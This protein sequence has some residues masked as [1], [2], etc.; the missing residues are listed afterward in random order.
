MSEKFLMALEGLPVFFGIYTTSV[1]AKAPE[2]KNKPNK[3]TL[4]SLSSFDIIPPI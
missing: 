3:L 1:A 2:V 4:I